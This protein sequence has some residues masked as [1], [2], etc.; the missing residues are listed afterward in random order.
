M[1][2]S[3]S[4]VSL[5]FSTLV[6][7]EGLSLFGGQKVLGDG[8]AVPGEN[9]LT[10]CKAEH[11]DDLLILDHINLTP[12]PPVPGSNLTIEAVG[13]LLKD[14]DK[15][16]YVRLQVKYGLIRLVNTQADLCEQTENVDLKCP[17]KKGKTTFKK[18][19]AIPNEVPPGTY[20]VFADAYTKDDEPIVCLEATVTFTM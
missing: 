9:P 18:D 17:I 3:L 5:L 12:N 16:A 14:I 15:N 10:Y 1:R 6:A 2:L 7:S 20:T 19:V 8:A 11:A 4:L 13:T